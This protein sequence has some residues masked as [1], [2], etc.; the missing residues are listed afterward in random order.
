MEFLRMMTNNDNTTSNG[1]SILL[2][3]FHSHGHDHV[4]HDGL[5]LVLELV[6]LVV[7]AVT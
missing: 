7:N 4:G 5:H 6:Y 1:S 2:T 3:E